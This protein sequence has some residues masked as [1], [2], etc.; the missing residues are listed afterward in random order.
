MAG[1]KLSPEELRKIADQITEQVIQLLDMRLPGVTK[2]NCTGTG[3]TC[4]NAEGYKCGGFGT[5][6]S[7][8]GDFT[9][10]GQSFKY[11]V[12]TP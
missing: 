6:H 1:E 7:C 2:Y 9:C 4:D 3:F 5:S 8:T 11:G 12:L 10:S